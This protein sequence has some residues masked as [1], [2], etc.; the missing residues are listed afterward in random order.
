LRWIRPALLG[1]AAA[2]CLL[3][4]AAAA[5]ATL[6]SLDPASGSQP[7]E[8]APLEVRITFSEPVTAFGRGIDVISPSGHLVSGTARPE[9]DALSVDVDSHDEQGTYL[10]EWRV[11]AQDTHPSRGAYTFS[12]GHPSV[13]PAGLATTGDLGSVAPLGLLLQALGRWLHFLGFALAFG[14]FAFQLLALREPELPSRLLRLVYAGILLLV[15]AEPVAL[16]GQAASFGSLDQAS[17]AD[18]LGSAFGRVLALRLGAPLLLWGILGALRQARGSGGWAVLALGVALALVDGLAGHTIRGVP[19]VFA[20]LLTAVHVASMATWVGGF[21]ALLAALPGSADRGRLVARFGRLAVAAVGVLL[22]SG[23][24]LAVAHL[25]SPADLV[26]SAYG[27]TL[28]IKLAAVAV[29]LAA[30]W[31][32]LRRLRSG[33]FEAAALA[34]VVAL[35]SLLAS[36]PP[37]R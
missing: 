31:L 5:H 30:A 24:I 32:G 11:V 14:P 7:L 37:P 9:G 33:R 13:A 16:A 28:A 21:A 36:L 4:V 26:F 19:A 25:R 10:V 17:L 29:A 35:A 1:L 12:V 27:L 18:A 15:A 23:G 2:L 34:G 3:P 20:Y 8:H 6:V 22:V